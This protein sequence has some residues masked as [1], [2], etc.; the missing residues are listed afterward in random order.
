VLIHKY[1]DAQSGA[2]KGKIRFGFTPHTI[3]TKSPATIFAGRNIGA[4]LNNLNFAE[5]SPKSVFVSLFST[6][7]RRLATRPGRFSY[8]TTS[9]VLLRVTPATFSSGNLDIERGCIIPGIGILLNI[10]NF[11]NERRTVGVR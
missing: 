8:T 3:L 7:F 6:R 1:G 4:S 5:A 9:T 10:F 2:D 11:L